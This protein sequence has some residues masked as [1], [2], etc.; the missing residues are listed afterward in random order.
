L[1]AGA[2][3]ATLGN[4]GNSS[5]LHGHMEAAVNASGLAPGTNE[6]MVDFWYTEVVERDLTS[7][8]PNGQGNRVDPTD[9][10]TP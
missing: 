5:A 6:A 1:S 10:L 7:D 4:S 9:M 3:V 8:P 2:A